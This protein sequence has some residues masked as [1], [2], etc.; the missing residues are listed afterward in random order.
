MFIANNKVLIKPFSKVVSPKSFFGSQGFDVVDG[1]LVVKLKKRNAA[2]PKPNT[3]QNNIFGEPIGNDFA[4]NDAC[5]QSLGS[6]LAENSNH[7]YKLNAKKIKRRLFAWFKTTATLKHLYFLTISFPLHTSDDAIFKY[8][9]VF[10]TKMRKKKL[11][12]S[13]IWVSERQKNGTLHFHILINKQIQVVTVN[14]LLRETLINAYS[15]DNLIFRG[16]VPTNYSGVDLAKDRKTR[17]VVNFADPSRANAISYYITK[18]IT[19]NVDEFS[20]LCWHCSRD[21]SNLFTYAVHD[22]GDSDFAEL[23]SKNKH[24]CIITDTAIIYIFE[25]DLV[26]CEIEKMQHFNNIISDSLS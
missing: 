2:K 3:T 6:S 22:Y 4:K 25:S 19:K 14:N 21:I 17:K 1:E 26:T 13:Y 24:K 10:L 12:H 20:H 8:F 16:Y 9:N 23:L 18:Y 11:L 7:T 15:A 5:V